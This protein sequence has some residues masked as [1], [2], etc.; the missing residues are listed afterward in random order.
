MEN[1]IGRCIAAVIAGSEFVRLE[2]QNQQRESSS[3]HVGQPLDSQ[4]QSVMSAQTSI[5]ST[6]QLFVKFSATMVLDSWN[7]TNRY[8]N[9]SFILCTNEIK[10]NYWLALFHDYVVF[11]GNLMVIIKD[12]SDTCYGN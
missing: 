9:E 4:I 1:E 2:C 10:D 11:L 6:M 5:K 8:V 7:E 3:G 12:I